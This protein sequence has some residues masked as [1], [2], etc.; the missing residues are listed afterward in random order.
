[1]LRNKANLLIITKRDKLCFLK[2]R[3]GKLSTGLHLE[4][5]LQSWGG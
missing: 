2:M 1:M 3:D 4:T 5:K